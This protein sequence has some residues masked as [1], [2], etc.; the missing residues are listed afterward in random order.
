MRV[1]SHPTRRAIIAGSLA[2]PLAMSA[3]GVPAVARAGTA[4]GIHKLA[5]GDL[6][7]TILSDGVLNIPTHLL[8]RDMEP[9]AIEGQLGNKLSAPGQVQ[10]GVNIV[11]VRS[12]A[13]LVQIDAGAGGTWQ[14]TVGKLADRLSTAGIDPGAITKV[15]IKHGHP[16]HLWGFVDEFDYS[17]RFVIAELFLPAPE[18]DYWR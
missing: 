11:L 4:A 7:I 10:Y 8:N 17:A 1:S 6:Q 5:L 2:V 18:L 14:P 15:V 16:D 3:A 9:S 13:D 12:G